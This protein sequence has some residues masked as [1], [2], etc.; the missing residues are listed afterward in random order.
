[1]N[2][3][4][5]RQDLAKVLNSHSV[6]AELGIPDYLLAKYVTNQLDQLM[7]L[8]VEIKKNASDDDPD[9]PNVFINVVKGLQQ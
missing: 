6:D 1:M 2:T 5:L 3:N 8:S 7:D 9:T 4:K